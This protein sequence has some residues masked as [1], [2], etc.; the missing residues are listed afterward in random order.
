MEIDLSKQV[1]IPE[2]RAKLNLINFHDL[3]TSSVARKNVYLVSN[4]WSNS[5][6]QTTTPKLF[7][8]GVRH[9]EGWLENSDETHIP[10]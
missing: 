7:R 8:W 9:G 2:E 1:S 6:V 3:I 10:E 4:I 5:A